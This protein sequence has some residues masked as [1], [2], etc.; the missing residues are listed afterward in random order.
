[1]FYK[2]DTECYDYPQLCIYQDKKISINNELITSNS[3]YSLYIH[4]PFCKS[5]CV[6]CNYYKVKTSN[7]SSLM[8][9]Y[10]EAII[11]EIKYY[12]NLLGEKVKIISIHFGGGTPTVLPLEVL[13]RILN[14]IQQNFFVVKNCEISM[15]GNI[16]EYSIEE[17]SRGLAQLKINRISYGVQSLS[18]DIRQRYGLNKNIDIIF[19]SYENIKAAGINDC[20]V[21]LMYGFP[22][23]NEEMLINDIEILFNLGINCIDMYALNVFPNTILYDKY[24]REKKWDLYN[25]KNNLSKYISVYEYLFNKKECNFL[26]SNTISIKSKE[27]SQY[28]KMRLGNNTNSGSNIIGLGPSAKGNINNYFYKNYTDL[29]QYIDAIKKA[30]TGLNVS[31]YI[32]EYELRKRLLVMFPNFT[33]INKHNLKINKEDERRINRL[34][35]EN[36]IYENNDFYYLTAK[37]CFYAGNISNYLCSENSRKKRIMSAAYNMQNKVNFYN[38]DKM[39]IKK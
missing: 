21:D 37:G 23:Q 16:R 29:E 10:E 34:I 35:S 31:N 4:V 17:Y 13:E 28:L 22:E 11:E 19:K 36:Y 1:M 24:H 25:N 27:P 2:R 3:E 6:F 12:S 30:K 5:F 15:E 7:Q 33:Y 9:E 8:K 14:S 20:N 26:M 38:Q 39:Q 32:S 18:P